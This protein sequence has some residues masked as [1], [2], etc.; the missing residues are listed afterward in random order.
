VIAKITSGQRW[1]VV[2]SQPTRAPLRQSNK[3]AI[4]LIIFSSI[5]KATHVYRPQAFEILTPHPR[6]QFRRVAVQQQR[7]QQRQSRAE[8]RQ[9]EEHG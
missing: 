2:R 1:Y 9:A 3:I 5:I 4:T 7:R 6:P 8:Q